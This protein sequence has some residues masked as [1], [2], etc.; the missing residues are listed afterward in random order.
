MTLFS[1]L[2]VASAGELFEVCLK[3]IFYLLLKIKLETAMKSVVK[4]SET[5]I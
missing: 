3:F 4:L 1:R 2:S 5:P